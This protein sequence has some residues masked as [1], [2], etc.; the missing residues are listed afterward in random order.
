MEKHKIEI[1]Y[2]KQYRYTT[3]NWKGHRVE[4]HF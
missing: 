2:Q 3:V 1:T 4:I